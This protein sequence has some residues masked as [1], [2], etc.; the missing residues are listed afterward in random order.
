MHCVEHSVGIRNLM[1]GGSCPKISNSPKSGTTP[2][3]QDTVYK[4]PMLAL[5]GVE[6]SMLLIN[7]FCG[8]LVQEHQKFVTF[9]QSL[10]SRSTKLADLVGQLEIE[11]G[12]KGSETTDGK[13][14][15]KPHASIFFLHYPYGCTQDVIPTC[16]TFPGSNPNHVAILRSVQSLE[17]S[18]EILNEQY[19]ACEIVKLDTD[20][21]RDPSTQEVGKQGLLDL[22]ICNHQVQKCTEYV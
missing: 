4:P 20:G 19:A 5:L 21:L 1:N 8:M 9:A 7:G 16:S 18:I 13:R 15:K 3:N 2:S 17:Q 22:R 10:L 6:Y 12:D 11:I 14:V